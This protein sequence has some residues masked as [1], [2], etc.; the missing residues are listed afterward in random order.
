M[1][2]SFDEI[3][4]AID[5]LPPVRLA[6]VNPVQ[7][8]IYQTMDEANKRGWIKQIIFKN[9][10]LEVASKN[11][12]LAVVN[13]KADFIMKGD[14]ETSILLQAV[15]DKNN[16]LIANQNLSHVAVLESSYYD[17]LMLM[18]DGGVNIK[19]SE[20]IMETILE[21]AV[22]FAKALQIEKPNIAFLSLI[23]KVV[24]KIPETILAES[25][26]EKYATDVRINVEG[27]MALDV[28]FSEKA[29][30]AKGIQTEIAGKIDIFIGPNISTINFTVKSLMIL[31]K[32]NGAGI[33]LG[34]KCPIIL[35]SRS[36]SIKTKLN[37]IALGILALKGV[38]NG[39]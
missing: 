36:D 25:M 7:D 10:N 35:L 37:S 26:A 5:G 34:S 19:L 33:I 15:M 28:A 30:Q 13:K 32:V 2:R 18:T 6:V 11:A 23:E 1:I 9:E 8:Y 14:V 17:R 27:P 24:D 31:G 4:K 3:Y 21:N 39:Y 16:G 22:D 12:V 20:S 29:A 38:Q